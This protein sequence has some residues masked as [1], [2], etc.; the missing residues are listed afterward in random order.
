MAWPGGEAAMAPWR[1]EAMMA[2]VRAGAASGVWRG[3]SSG[4]EGQRRGVT[5]LGGSGAVSA[6][7]GALECLRAQ[8]RGG[9]ARE[10]ERGER[11]REWREKER[12]KGLTQIKLKIFN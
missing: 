3:H 12:V 8:D 7:A 4:V 2:S 10:R 9:S 6:R 5:A 1:A 11:E